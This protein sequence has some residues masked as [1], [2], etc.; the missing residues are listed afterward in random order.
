MRNEM[1]KN[2]TRMVVTAF[3]LLACASCATNFTGSPYV[4]NGRA[5]CEAKC[6][7]VG[8]E[9]A[10]V[11]YMG[12]YSDACVCA[13]PGQRAEVMREATAAVAGAGAGVAMQMQRQQRQAQANGF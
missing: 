12:E 11:V 8:M 2:R 7:S 1:K 6:R 13:V 5:G 4:E 3:M 9:V 10:G